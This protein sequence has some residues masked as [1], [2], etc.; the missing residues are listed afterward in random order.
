[1]QATKPRTGFPRCQG[2]IQ[3]GRRYTRSLQGIHLILH[4]CDQ[5]RDHHRQSGSHQGGQL[6]TEGFSAARWQ[7]RKYIP[8]RQRIRDDRFLTRTKRFKA[9]HFLQQSAELT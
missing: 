5:G 7:Q 6:I 9:E 4:Q 3:E 1:M 8:A 2:G